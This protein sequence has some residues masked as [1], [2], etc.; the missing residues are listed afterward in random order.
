SYLVIKKVILILKN[1]TYNNPQI[2]KCFFQFRGLSAIIG[3]IKFIDGLL[4]HCVDLGQQKTF[5]FGEVFNFEEISELRNQIKL[6]SKYKIIE[7]S[8]IDDS[9][10]IV[11]DQSVT[12]ITFPLIINNK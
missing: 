10:K 12:K 9:I 4:G 3:N 1:K 11:N 6:F 8:L 2:S 5:S 7:E